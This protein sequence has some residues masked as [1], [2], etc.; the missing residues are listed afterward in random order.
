MKAKGP[1]APADPAFVREILESAEGFAR[2]AGVV[3]LR[4][5][6][7]VV[8]GQA[9]GDGSP[10]TVADREAEALLRELIGA[11][12]PHHGILGEEFGES[13]PEAP[14]RWILDPIDGTRSFMRGVPLF[15][16]LIGVEISG[17]ASVGVAYFPALGEMVSAGLGQGA[18]WNGRTA[19]VSTVRN[20]SAALVLTTDVEAVSQR[21]WA[22]DWNR[23]TRQAA[24]ART[25]GDCYGHVLVAT[26]RAEIMVDPILKV[27]DAAPFVPILTEAGGHFTDLTGTPTIHGGCG[28][29]TNAALHE[30][31]LGVLGKRAGERVSG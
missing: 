8:P 1:A 24:F 2:E 5:Y 13:A 6:G 30:M 7:A 28:I 14:I 21:G 27:W 4:Y 3:V 17:T 12:Y 15:G 22:E 23:L 19:R 29:S 11:R 20:L 9:K 26:G 18:R 25:W 31:A 16:M 10:V